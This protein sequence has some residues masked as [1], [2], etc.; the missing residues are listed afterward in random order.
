MLRVLSRLPRTRLK[1]G[2][3]CPRTSLAPDGSQRP[4][5]LSAYGFQYSL[6][7]GHRAGLLGALLQ[8]GWPRAPPPLHRAILL[9]AGQEHEGHEESPV[10]RAPSPPTSQLPEE[11]RACLC[12]RG[13]PC[14]QGCAPPPP[15]RVSLSQTWLHLR[16]LGAW[17]SREPGVPFH[18]S[19]PPQPPPWLRLQGGAGG[20]RGACVVSD[21]PE[22]GLAGSKRG[23]RRQQT[24]PLLGE[25]GEEPG[26]SCLG[27]LHCV[28]GALGL[29]PPAHRLSGRMIHW[30]AQGQPWQ[31]R[32][33][34]RCPG[35]R[36][37]PPVPLDHQ[38][39]EPAPPPAPK[40][41]SCP[42]LPAVL[43]P[44]Q[45]R[46]VHCVLAVPGS[47]QSRVDPQTPP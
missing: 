6:S 34:E 26:C 28:L 39:A 12:G 10:P 46:H 27:C 3:H 36:P 31:D 38:A 15:Q 8:L 21:A 1:C 17:R 9:R 16:A 47:I 14:P 30:A 45:C 25:P 19:A 2:Q 37:G 24:P 11:E 7:S 33:G 40:A 22:P 44:A 29:G 42:L 4:L 18:A 35:Q 13:R 5:R 32:R 23:L 41:A 20:C 43:G